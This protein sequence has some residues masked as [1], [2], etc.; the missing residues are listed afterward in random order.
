LINVAIFC[1]ALV[2]NICILYYQTGPVSTPNLPKKD[3]ILTRKRLTN[4]AEYVIINYAPDACNS[5]SKKRFH[6]WAIRG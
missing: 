2:V 1:P 4:L 3:F 5:V 6:K